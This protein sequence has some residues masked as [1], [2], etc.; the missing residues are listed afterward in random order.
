MYVNRTMQNLKEKQAA[1]TRAVLVK[2]ARRLFAKRGYGGVS[3]EEVVASARLTRGALYHH[4]KNGKAGLF[5]AVV[6]EAMQ[7][8]RERIAK[9]ARGA[10]DPL[11]ALELGVSA[12]LDACTTPELQRILLVD[13]PAVLGW[14]AWRALDLEHGIGLLRDGLRRAAAAGQMDLPDVE[15]ASHLVAGALIDGAMII[16]SAKRHKIARRQVERSMLDL[17]R[18]FAC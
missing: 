3:A 6:V 1:K 2:T 10:R 5:R 18:G 15:T 8:V 7:E 12:F 16:A 14:Q 17:L 11:K 13:G 9:A 4:F